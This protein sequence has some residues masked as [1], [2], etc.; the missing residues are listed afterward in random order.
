M[1]AIAELPVHVA[2]NRDPQ[3]CFWY[4]G[5]FVCVLASGDETG[6]RYSLTEV[7][8]IRGIGAV[9]PMHIH[10]REQECFLVQ[11]GSI[12]CYVGDATVD[13]E[14][15]GFIAL[16]PHVPHYYEITS[17]SAVLLNIC[18][19]AGFEEFYRALSMPAE[20][21]AMPSSAP[22]VDIPRVIETAN[23]FGIT[24]LPPA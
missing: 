7:S 24:I 20:Q 6:G 2:T 21:L 3:R 4:A 11:E 18:A 1:N 16:P 10:T 15:G 5:Y 22:P 23:R 19:P 14:R 17:E 8:G 9:P 12:R 13:V